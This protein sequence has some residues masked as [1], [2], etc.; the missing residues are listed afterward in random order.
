MSLEFV[1]QSSKYYNK[2]HSQFPMVIT[3]TMNHALGNLYFAL[4]KR[5]NALMLF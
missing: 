3:T 4:L 5:Q 1:S 2:L